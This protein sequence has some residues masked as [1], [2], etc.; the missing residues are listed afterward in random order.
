[1]GKD[2]DNPGAPA[3]GD[4][5][6]QAEKSQPAA[7]TMV[8]LDADVHYPGPKKLTVIMV[9]LYLSMLLVAIVCRYIYIL[10]HGSLDCTQTS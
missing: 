6:M 10:S 8:R 7:A 1:M 5:D 9:S 3:R 2:L 4:G